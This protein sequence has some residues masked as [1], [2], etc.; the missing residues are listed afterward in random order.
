MRPRRLP[1]PPPPLQFRRARPADIDAMSAIRLS[2]IE[3]VLTDPNKVTRQMYADYL[4]VLGRG[5]VCCRGKT[6]VGF[7]YASRHDASIWALFVMPGHERRGIGRRLLAL[8]VDWLFA[9]GAGAVTLT[10][11]AGTRAERVYLHAGWTREAG[12]GQRNVTFRK[13]AAAVPAPCAT[14]VT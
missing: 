4:H 3:N 11:G 8:A 13:F 12:P 14:S 6:V 1:F 7:A 9:L 2:V 10:T 5:W